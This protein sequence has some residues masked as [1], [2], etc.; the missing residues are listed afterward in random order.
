MGLTREEKRDGTAK[1]TFNHDLKEI[2]FM[3]CVIIH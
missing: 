3:H 1:N 2:F